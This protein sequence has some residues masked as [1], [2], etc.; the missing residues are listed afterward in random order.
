M[1]CHS[2]VARF[3]LHCSM[4]GG[5]GVK[6]T[7]LTEIAAPHG[8]AIARL[9]SLVLASYSVSSRSA[10]QPG[11][12]RSCRNQHRG[13][14]GWAE[15]VLTC[16]GIMGDGGSE[17]HARRAASCGGHGQGSNVEHC[18]QQLGLGHARVAHHERI[19]VPA[20]VRACMHR[21]SDSAST[22]ALHKEICSGKACSSNGKIAGNSCAADTCMWEIHTQR[23]LLRNWYRQSGV[24]CHAAPVRLQVPYAATHAPVCSCCSHAGLNL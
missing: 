1:T 18:A 20:Q 12:D 21:S 22:H 2:S 10:G 24:Q 15:S 3:G 5:A 14:A 6:A 9:P 17:A 7:G 23:G 11:A 19:D 13:A 8:T 4:D 16:V